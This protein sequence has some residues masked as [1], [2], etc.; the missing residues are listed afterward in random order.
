MPPLQR[1]W[2]PVVTVVLVLLQGCA[3]QATRV[4]SAG[5]A[6]P[7]IGPA[8]WS[9]EQIEPAPVLPTAATR[10]ADDVPPLD[11]IDLFARARAEAQNG[12]RT[13]A[14]ALLERAIA[15]DPNSYEL[16]YELGAIRRQG[17]GYQPLALQAFERAAAIDPDRLDV[18]VDIAR[19]LL[20]KGDT[21]G[22]LRR[23]R[24][25]IQTSQYAAG[26]LRSAETDFL[27][28]HVLREQ[29][30]DRA[31]LDRFE[32]LIDR[33]ARGDIDRSQDVAGILSTR[34]YMQV[35]DLY[36][37]HDRPTDALAAYRLAEGTL[38]GVR[39]ID[40]QGRIV[41]AMMLSGQVQQ[42]V[43]RAADV[44]RQ[45]GASPASLSLLR[46]V[47]AATG[48][49]EG[50]AAALA[51]L[52]RQFPDDRPIL[53][54]LCEV[55]AADGQFPDADARLA[56]AWERTPGNGP[57]LARWFRLRF[58]HSAP[59]AIRLLVEL[60]AD[61]PELADAIEPVWQRLRSVD[62]HRRLPIDQLAAL[63][64]PERLG[65]AHKYIVWRVATD[66][67][68]T[69][70]AQK[71]LDES[72]AARP[73]FAP[74]WLARVREV[75]DDERLAGRSRLSAATKLASDAEL[76]GAPGLA[77]LL[78]G[79]IALFRGDTA[80][81]LACFKS[82][83]GRL[84]GPRPRLGIARVLLATGERAAAVETLW[85]ISQQHPTCEAAY[86][87]LNE[88][89]D[90]AEPAKVFD[91]WQAVQPVGEPAN[92]ALLLAQ[93]EDQFV[94]G[95]AEGAE[96]LLS[97]LERSSPAD[98]GL[99]EMAER[100]SRAK[101]DS[102]GGE[103]ADAL[104]NVRLEHLLNEGDKIGR[105]GLVEVATRLARIYVGNG[106]TKAATRALDVARA[107]IGTAEPDLLHR[108]ATAY[109]TAG[110]PDVAERL[111]AEALEADPLHAGSAFELSSLWAEQGRHL[112]AAGRLA[113]DLARRFPL[114]PLYRGNVG[115][116][117]Y[118]AGDLE[119]AK[120][121]LLSAVS[122][123]E[124][125]LPPLPPPQGNDS[126]DVP[127]AGAK[128]DRA[129]PVLLDRAG[130]AL[131]RLG[132][133]QTAASFWERAQRR[134][135]DADV[136]TAARPD[137]DALRRTLPRKLQQHR[138]GQDVQVSSVAAGSGN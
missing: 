53:F 68:R 84:S 18:Q 16:H 11:A 3:Q 56:S 54:A 1:V 57:L 108:L 9:L 117:L 78:R 121:E 45:F 98:S 63:S 79:E 44:V 70:L 83:A 74:A 82:A 47:Y 19:Q 40:V 64:F 114:N 128:P 81:A 131:Y 7:A 90:L 28:A 50:V 72:L 102:D 60:L 66:W 23:L 105:P 48:R 32:L 135:G 134:L 95:R 109:R 2:V 29:G 52:H 123:S 119:A 34:L 80:E 20:A 86:A 61:H 58:D 30:Y 8:S 26:D 5:P 103:V 22:A 130:D 94:R 96:L 65:A 101:A 36:L 4:S 126:A 6:K 97:E 127:A 111:M 132:D 112:G 77:D 59:A 113:R 21:A 31:A 27:L 136:A 138:T 137:V 71:S 115:W 67:P 12:R 106:R 17:L 46:D 51:D 15:L 92:P 100:I 85:Q 107:A 24:L 69:S 87:Q 39:D 37:K 129:D 33:L 116:V 14:A 38:D 133:R 10:P 55:L 75:L 125:S 91:A 49:P 62:G 43:S 76:G 35:G 88:Q 99:L 93:A 122:L 42:G 41:R 104:F 89:P 120:A 110:E 73:P 124:E 25:A 13:A 118:R